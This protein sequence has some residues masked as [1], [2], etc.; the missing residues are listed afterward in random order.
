MSQ[1]KNRKNKNNPYGLNSNQLKFCKNYIDGMNLVDS[2]V[3]AYGANS[4]RQYDRFCAHKLF[5]RKIIKQHIE[6][7]QG[8][9]LEKYII[10][11]QWMVDQYLEVIQSAIE[12]GNVNRDGS[13]TID[14][15]NW[16]KALAQLSKL[17]GLDEPT[18]VN[19]NVTDFVAKFGDINESDKKEN[20]EE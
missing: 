12:D 1:T 2:Y 20:E 7:L 13:V 4:N 19:L 17:L 14:R 5:A 6:F 11:K 18:D 16:N 8:E 9:I 10:D 15:T 3:D